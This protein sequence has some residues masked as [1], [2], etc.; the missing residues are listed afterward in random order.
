MLE[1]SSV[2]VLVVCHHE[3]ALSSEL[4]GIWWNLFAAGIVLALCHII[5]KEKEGSS[6][7]SHTD[8]KHRVTSGRI[9]WIMRNN[10]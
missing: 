3:K 9:M 5:N 8:P 1:L 4:R 7:G 10:K 2:V 6:I